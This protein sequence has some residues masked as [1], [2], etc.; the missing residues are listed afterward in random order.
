VTGDRLFELH[1]PSVRRVRIAPTTLEEETAAVRANMPIGGRVFL[2]GTGTVTGSKHD[3][4]NGALAQE[5][6]IT[7]D[8]CYE[9]TPD[10]PESGWEML[11][12]F[13][14]TSEREPRLLDEVDA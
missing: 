13:R 10:D 7:L 12:E 11:V 5:L 4:K 9:V 3:L 14:G 8:E 1:E 2:V 6:T